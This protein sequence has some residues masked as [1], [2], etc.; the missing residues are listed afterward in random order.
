MFDWTSLGGLLT[1][2]GLFL[3]VVGVILVLVLRGASLKPAVGVILVGIVILVI[4]LGAVALAPTSTSAAAAPPTATINVLSGTSPA[5]PSGC[6]LLSTT[7]VINCDVV[8]NSTSGYLAISP[9]V[10]DTFHLP[11]YLDAPFNMIRT[12]AV[13]QTY[14]FASTLTGIATFSSIGSNPTTYAPVGY[15]TATSTQPGQWQVYPDQGTLAGQ[16]PTVVAPTTATGIETTGVPLQA[17]SSK[18]IGWHITLAGSNGTAFPNAA[19]QAWTNYTAEPTTF[20]FANAG[21]GGTWT[22]NW[23]LIGWHA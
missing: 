16:K 14:S 2:F 21:T 12:D 8:F 4:G 17:F 22:V 23:I 20:A 11:V 6:T 13:N 10:A 18:I 19:A 7:N 1:I 5:L 9:T 3:A 15:K